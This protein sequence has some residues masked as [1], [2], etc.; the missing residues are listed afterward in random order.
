MDNTLY[1]T[2]KHSITGGTTN[3]QPS[4]PYAIDSNGTYYFTVTGIVNG[5]IYTKEVS[6]IVDQFNDR[7]EYASKNTEKTYPDGKVWI[8]EGFKVADDS[9][10]NVQGG[11]VIEDR[12]GNQFVWVPVTS[13]DDY[14]RTWYSGS[15]SFIEYSETLSSE[16]KISIE[17]YKGGYIGRY[18]A[19]DKEST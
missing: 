1:I 5:K 19:G 17:T 2:F 9:S 13:I 11:V 12:A 16:E 8:P 18:E 3:V 10:E 6:V 7:Y 4:V 14:K 15:G